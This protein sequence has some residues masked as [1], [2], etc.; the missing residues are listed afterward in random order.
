[1]LYALVSLC[2]GCGLLGLGTAV[3][4]WAPWLGPRAGFRRAE[5]P[6]D[7]VDVSPAGS[8]LRCNWNTGDTL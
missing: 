4:P 2:F 7:E 8:C 3:V 1:M 5:R 6:N